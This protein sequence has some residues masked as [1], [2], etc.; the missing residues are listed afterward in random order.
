MNQLVTV[1]PYVLPPLLGAIIGY[2]TNALAIRMLFRPLTEKRVL[3]IRVPLTPGIIP[4]RR[5][6]LAESIA[7]MVSQKLLTEEV[8]VEKVRDS[9]FRLSLRRS[10]S[11]LSR[12]IL[13]GRSDQQAS[14]APKAGSEAT[15]TV[16]YLVQDLLSA[17]FR[18]ESFQATAQTLTAKA[19]SGVLAMN[20]GA[21]I[22]EKSRIATATAHL[23]RSL[24]SG[25]SADAAIGAIQ[26]WINRHLDANTPLRD[27]VG[28]KSVA[29]LLQV[30][31]PLY[32]PIAEMVLGFLKHHRTR[33]ELSIHG[34]D[35]LKRILKRLNVLQRLLVSATQ[36][37]RNLNQNMPAIVNDVIETL[38]RAVASDHNRHR[39]ISITR[40]KL[41]TWARTGV[42][43]LSDEFKIDIRATLSRLIKLVATLLA[44]DDVQSQISVAVAGLADRWRE[45]TIAQVAEQLT[46]A[47]H[48]E[49]VE[50]AAEIVGRWTAEERHREQLA[51]VV[52][53]F[54]RGLTEAGKADGSPNARS[55]IGRLFP[56]SRAEKETLD[57]FLTDQA[58]YQIQNRVPE[59]LHGLDV[60]TMVVNKINALDVKS[61][62]QL[63]LMVIAKHLKWINLF[64]AILG[65]LIG[66]IQILLGTLT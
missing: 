10:V 48:Q 18:S 17:F 54:V 24:T 4:K 13:E 60:H 14:A 29:Q 47:G 8:V 44:R 28:R 37:D 35:L 57:D 63:L 61:V 45:K 19:T 7:Q 34:R 56:L 64:G 55:G 65:A 20:A 16:G 26:T 58:L 32:G 27:L 6:Q 39:V 15:A 11:N 50:H 41:M 33:E 2:V 30:I 51:H 12:D 21:L 31:P 49:V 23:V 22:P 9:E 38:E 40:R 53:G 46:G 52:S 59:L 3:G 5:H 36:Y 43:D 62:E 66:G 25:E 1:L 42:R